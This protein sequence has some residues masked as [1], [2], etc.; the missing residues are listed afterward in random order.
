MRAYEM[1]SKS[2]NFSNLNLP[3]SSLYLLAAPSTEET[4]RVEVIERASSGEILRHADIKEII[5][6]HAETGQGEH[7][8]ADHGELPY[9]LRRRKDG[10]IDHRLEHFLNAISSFCGAAAH[11]PVED[12]KFPPTLTREMVANARKEVK[13]AIAELHKLDTRLAAAEHTQSEQTAA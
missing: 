6:Q 8:Q 9:Y 12:I 3:V 2:E 11:I 7:E 4:A 1:S 10:R 13:E 5:N